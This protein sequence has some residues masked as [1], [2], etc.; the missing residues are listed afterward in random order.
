MAKPLERLRRRL[1]LRPSTSFTG[2]FLPLLVSKGNAL[3]TRFSAISN[4]YIASFL[5]AWGASPGETSQAAGNDKKRL[6]LQATDFTTLQQLHNPQYLYQLKLTIE[7][8]TH[9]FLGE[10]VYLQL[11]TNCMVVLLISDV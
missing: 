5:A 11:L 4:D 2:L 6:F 3:R 8:S 1:R 10:A 9:T 7:N